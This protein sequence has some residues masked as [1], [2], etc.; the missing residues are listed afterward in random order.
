MPSIIQLETSILNAEK[1][2]SNLMDKVVE[3]EM[4]L[5]PVI[6]SI[7]CRANELFLTIEAIRFLFDMEIYTDDA[8]CMSLYKK[9]MYQIGVYSGDPT[10][11]NTLLQPIN[12]TWL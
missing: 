4:Q 9:M 8:T 10:L 1:Y 11:D 2:F 12:E 7:D 5:Q 6:S 3:N